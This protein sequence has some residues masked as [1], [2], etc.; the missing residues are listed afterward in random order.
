MENL[1]EEKIIDEEQKKAEEER[2]KPHRPKLPEAKK[3]YEFET[4][5]NPKDLEEFERNRKEAIEV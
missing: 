4:H 3:H 2:Q 5:D 1:K